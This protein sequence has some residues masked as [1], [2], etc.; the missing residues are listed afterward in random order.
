MENGMKSAVEQMKKKKES[1]LNYIYSQT[2]NFVYLRAKS[3]LKHEEEVKQLMQ[4][5]YVELYRSSDE[6]RLENLYEWLGKEV[7]RLG[8]GHFK[9]R[10]EREVA[11]MEMED[12]EL[13][14]KKKHHLSESVE[15]I[16]DTLEQFPDLYQ[17]TLF[18][19]Y[20]DYLK[21][22]EIAKLMDCKP[23]VIV[24]RLNYARKYLKK[25]M[26]NV[27]EGSEE[28]EERRGAF[29]VE[30][31]CLALRK[32][33]VDHCLGITSAQSVYYNVCKT[34]GLKGQ[35]ISLDGKEFAGVKKTVIYYK[36][37]DW[38]PI[39]EEIIIYEKKRRWDKRL[40]VYI[41]GAAAVLVLVIVVIVTVVSQPEKKKPSSEN[42]KVIKEKEESKKE[43]PKKEDADVQESEK[44]SDGTTD[45]SAS[46]PTEET[47]NEPTDGTAGEPADATANESAEESVS[48]PTEESTESE[49]IFPDS[50][51]TELTWED[52]RGHTK[53]ELRLARNEIF[54]R[55][56]VI[57]GVEDL[58]TYFRSKSW[59][60]PIFSIGEF[61][62]T[63]ELSMVEE[64]NISLISE[65]ES[66]M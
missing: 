47:A 56:G 13:N 48:E 34:L 49:Y 29:S 64:K 40:T 35:S 55:H 45:A 52:V 59:Y 18:A 11:F 54:A 46:E 43:K 32:W 4:T 23:G 25:S 28:D 30:A 17:A 12:E 58:D 9:K 61:L 31:V 42:P 16:C 15:L 57:F 8:C 2:Y 27:Q 14:P 65:V 44:Q 63:V 39:Q 24:N 21:I 3:I 62:D 6:I 50:G 33:A 60:T 66:G 1:G 5:V 20:F 41:A 26:E 19:F 10:K 7:Y 38:N 53:E 36:P 22:A 37:D 51:T